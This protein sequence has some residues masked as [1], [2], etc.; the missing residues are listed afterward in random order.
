MENNQIE[1]RGNSVL[2]VNGQLDGTIVRIAAVGNEL[3]MR[4]L[5]S[6]ILENARSYG[7]YR[8]N[9]PETIEAQYAE[10]VKLAKR[11]FPSVD[12]R[13]LH[14]KVN[15]Y[16]DAHAGF[17]L[18][19]HECGLYGAVFDYYSAATPLKVEELSDFLSLQNQAGGIYMNAI[20]TGTYNPGYSGTE[21][22][23]F[24]GQ[25]SDDFELYL[26]MAYVLHFR[27]FSQNDPDAFLTLINN[28]SYIE[29]YPPQEI[30]IRLKKS[31]KKKRFDKDNPNFIEWTQDTAL[32]SGVLN[33]PVS[34][35]EQYS[36]AYNIRTMV[37]YHL[38]FDGYDD[39]ESEID[40]LGAICFGLYDETAFFIRPEHADD[41]LRYTENEAIKT[42][43]ALFR[44][45]YSAGLTDE[46]QKEYEKL[47][48]RR[49]KQVVRIAADGDKVFVLQKLIDIGVVNE[50][51]AAD[52]SANNLPPKCA[53]VLNAYLSDLAQKKES[54]RNT[55]Q[56]AGEQESLTRV[57]L[58]RAWENDVV[59]QICNSCDR[60]IITLKKDGTVISNYPETSSWEDIVSVFC[61]CGILG[62]ITKSGNILCCKT[63]DHPHAVNIEQGLSGWT[64]IA[65]VTVW[66]RQEFMWKDKLEDAYCVGIKKDGSVVSCG[67]K[68]RGDTSSSW[69][70]VKQ[71]V[72]DKNAFAAVHHDGTVSAFGR[73][74]PLAA[75]TNIDRASIYAPNLIAKDGSGIVFMD[76]NHIYENV[77]NYADFDTT[78]WIS[79][80][81]KGLETSHSLDGYVPKPDIL[82][83]R[84]EE[85]GTV[86]VRLR[87]F[88][89]P[90][91][92]VC[93]YNEGTYCAAMAV[94]YV[95]GTVRLFADNRKP[96]EIAAKSATRIG[97]EEGC[98][99]AYCKK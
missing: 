26:E 27:Q 5:L 56:A 37:S 25:I 90:L 29:K 32:M 66:D 44:M 87:K 67:K 11:E 19:K 12:L 34:A 63:K 1:I 89:D 49:I 20:S 14:P 48:R 96:G 65:S 91:N 15:E 45:M 3:E 24:H 82:T 42:R 58:Y 50:K 72:M 9:I 93:I 81:E 23:L 86:E 2:Y 53:K 88:K 4:K 30:I 85:G 79:F 43:A 47:L 31:L 68:L 84:K 13:Y 41:Y 35:T 95:N 73:L 77:R 36:A 80:C 38:L 6:A 57:E 76:A 46:H 21:Y 64:D 22:T 69:K 75:Y 17:R 33:E 78:Q 40:V 39:L 8:D 98:I 18:V 83:L 28:V 61:V 92:F 59:M 94:L 51:N 7:D 70:N 54:V 71:I 97:V 52:L 16:E 60:Q 99:V 74:T 62:G 55:M 10:I